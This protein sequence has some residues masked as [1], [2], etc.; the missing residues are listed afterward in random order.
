MSSP[1]VLMFGGLA[2]FYGVLLLLHTLCGSAPNS[3]ALAL[4]NKTGIEVKLFQIPMVQ[5]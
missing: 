5:E 2:V 4:A 3:P 1:L